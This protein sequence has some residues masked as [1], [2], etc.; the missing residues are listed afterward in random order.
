MKTFTLD[1]AAL[2]AK[3]PLKSVQN[4][5]QRGKLKTFKKVIGATRRLVVVQPELDRWIAARAAFFVKPKA[6]E[7]TT[8]PPKSPARKRRR[9]VATVRAG[10]AIPKLPGTFFIPSFGKPIT[11]AASRDGDF[12]DLAATTSVSDAMRAFERARTRAI[13]AVRAELR[14]LGA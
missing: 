9:R 7:K 10:Q 5:V 13:E 3:C 11:I 4:A 2:I 8:A 1:Q 6:I 12:Y 14:S